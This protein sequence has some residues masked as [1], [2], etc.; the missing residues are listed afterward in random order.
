MN[1]YRTWDRDFLLDIRNHK[2]EYDYIMEYA[3][4]VYNE[5]LNLIETSTLPAEPDYNEINNI[6]LT[7]RKI[8]Y[9]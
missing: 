9:K 7:A 8:A 1:V 3:E 4:N 6:L 5:M 2:F